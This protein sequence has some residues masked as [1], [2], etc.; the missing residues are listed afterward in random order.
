MNRKLAA[1]LSLAALALPLLALCFAGCAQSGA[2]AGKAPKDRDAV[3]RQNRFPQAELDAANERLATADAQ[4]KAA[5]A[6]VEA[7]MRAGQV[8][9]LTTQIRQ[10]PQRELLPP[11]SLPAAD[12]ELW[13][14]QKPAA[15]EAREIDGKPIPARAR[16][17]P[18]RP[19]AAASS[20][21][22]CR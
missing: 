19:A 6:E 7:L 9:N 2:D 5:P 1:G 20:R 13:V 14:I 18:S 16:S 8:Q 10:T 17:S 11:G 12:E 22:P 4:S 15:P 21:R 3:W